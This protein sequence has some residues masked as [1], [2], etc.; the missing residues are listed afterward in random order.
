M[1]VTKIKCNRGEYDLPS[2]VNDGSN[3]SLA[4]NQTE[5]GSIASKSTW[6]DLGVNCPE[7]EMVCSPASQKC[8]VIGTSG[9]SYATKAAKVVDSGRTDQTWETDFSVSPPQPI[10][11]EIDHG[12]KASARQER[13]S[14]NTSTAQVPVPSKVELHSTETKT[15]SLG[16]QNLRQQPVS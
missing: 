5:V 13:T 7:G 2:V 6:P 9:D 11:A 15:Q 8:P 14:L 12:A 1:E 3:F 16:S 10:Y 4:S